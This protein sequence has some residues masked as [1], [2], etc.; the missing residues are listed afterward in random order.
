MS[1]SVHEGRNF[2]TFANDTVVVCLHED[3]GS[4]NFPNDWVCSVFAG[5]RCICGMYDG[6]SL[7]EAIKNAAD[8]AG[9]VSEAFGEI[10]DS[11]RAY[12]ASCTE[13]E[14]ERR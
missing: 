7:E 3:G 6:I 10:S 5:D 8:Y 2:L 14:G 13:S 12:A 1:V 9:G 11:L 4:P